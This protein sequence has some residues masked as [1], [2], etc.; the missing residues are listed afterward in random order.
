[1]AI[2]IEHARESVLERLKPPP[3]FKVVLLNDDFTPMDFVT[4]LLVHLFHKGALE[5]EQIMLQIHQQGQGIGGIY[6][7]DIAETKQYQ[8]MQQSREQGHPLKCVLEEDQ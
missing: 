6:A 7:H 4:D 1:M 8:V 2:E 3:L 5:A